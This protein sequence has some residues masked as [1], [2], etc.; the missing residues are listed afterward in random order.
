MGDNIIVFLTKHVDVISISENKISNPDYLPLP[1][2][3]FPFNTRKLQKY[4]LWKM[5]SIFWQHKLAS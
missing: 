5:N 3:K 4:Y 2:I 1:S